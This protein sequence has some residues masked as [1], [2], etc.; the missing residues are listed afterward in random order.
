[1]RQRLSIVGWGTWLV[2]LAAVAL[3]SSAHASSI[4]RECRRACSDEIT[5]CVAAGSR[6]AVC[7]RQIL[8]RC[9]REGLAVCLSPA[10]SGTAWGSLT[11]PSGLTATASS[12]STID[13]RWSDTNSRENGETVGRSL[14]GTSFTI[15]ATLPSNT[16][17]Y[18]DSSCA[19][20][21]TYYYR[22]QAFGR[23]GSYSPYS[24]VASATTLA[25]AV[26][27]TTM[28][29]ST[30]TLPSDR[31]PPSFPTG[32]TAS[33]VSCSQINLAWRASTDTGGSGLKGYNV[34]V[35][36][37]YTWTFLKQVPAPAT[38]TSDTG[39]TGS[40]T[41][42]YAV[43]AVDGAGNESV[44][45]AWANA[46]TSACTTSTSTTSTTTTTTST[47]STTKPPTTTTST[48]TTTTIP[49][50]TSSTT[51]STTSTTT[52]PTTT[53]STSTTTTIPTTTSSTTTSTTST[54]RPPTTTTSTSTTTTTTQPP[55]TTTSTTTTTRPPTTTTSS[56]SSTTT[57]TLLSPPPAPTGLS[58]T[59]MSCQ[60]VS[61]RWTLSS[62]TVSGYNVYRKLSTDASY[63]MLTQVGA[64]PALPVLDATASESRLYSYGVT[65]VNQAGSSPM[66]T[67]RFKATTGFGRSAWSWS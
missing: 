60:D 34:Y 16:L 20:G 38:S 65:A 7:R 47:T 54:T 59:T 29:T 30:T 57:T 3:A 5:A 51:T 44:Q 31:T 24:N 12:S 37:N 42:Y 62:G 58:T 64:T 48:S 4:G 6:R 35:W 1:M 9:R 17:S 49:T 2:L 39:L 25:V 32:L 67:A 18:H 23:H 36:R 8:G 52:P 50:T 45:S 33:A 27:T 13:L 43:S 19:A 10:A 56:T 40:S 22:V 15:I 63:T 66:A 53:T 21:T 11:A 28:T 41:Y 26:T 14:D 61:L 55:T 46:T